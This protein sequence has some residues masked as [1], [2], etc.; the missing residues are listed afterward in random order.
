MKLQAHE[1]D[2]ANQI[3][4][5]ALQRAYIDTSRLRLTFEGGLVRLVGRVNSAAQRRFAEEIVKVAC[6]PRD[7]ENELTITSA[8]APTYF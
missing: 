2:Y 3:A 6:W 1:D 4:Q 8:P 5:A 7:L